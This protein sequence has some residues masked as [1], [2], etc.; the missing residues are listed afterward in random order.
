MLLLAAAFFLTALLYASV[1]FGGGSTYIALLVLTGVTQG[2]VPVVAPLCNIIV[3]TGG[4]IRY[5]RVGLVPWRRVVPLVAASAPMAYLGGLTPVSETLFVALLAGSLLVAGLLLLVQPVRAIE[6][7]RPASRAG[8]AA[9]GSAIGYLSGLVG[10]GGGIFLSPLQHLMRWAGARQIAATAS[11]FIL[12]NALAGL[13][14]QLTKL[15]TA[16]LTAIVPFWPLFVA[17]A[18]GG[19]LAATPAS[20]C[21]VRVRCGARRVR[22]CLRSRRNCCGKPSRIRA[23]DRFADT[24]VSL[25]RD[26]VEHVDVL[27]VGAGLSGIGMAWHLQD[28]CPGKSYAIVEAR[29]AIGGTWDLFRYPGIRSDSDMFTLGYHFKPWLGEKSIADGASIRDYV[30]EAAHEHGIDRHIR[31]GH[32][33]ER[34]EWSSATATWTVSCTRGGATVT[35]SAGFVVMASG[36]YRYDDCYT[37]HFEGL[38]DFAGQV[39]HPQHWPEA[40]DY[41]GKRIVVI[42]SGATAMTL[43][44]ALAE[45]AGHVVMLQRSPTYVADVPARDARADGFRRRLPE[46]LA[47]RAARAWKI[48]QSMAMFKLMRRYPARARQQLI[49][50][51]R[52]ALGPDYDV[53]RHFTPRYNPWDQRLCA[54]PDGDLFAAIRSGKVEVV[55]E[56][57]DRFVADGIRLASGD[58]LP[59]DIVVTAT[60][61][62]MQLFGGAALVV[63]GEPVAM[64][65]TMLYKGMMIGGVPNMSVMIGYN[66]ASWT[67]KA[68]LSAQHTCRIVNTMARRARRLRRRFSTARR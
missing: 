65:E 27:I 4:T 66:N 26:R 58:V 24:H 1:G 16:G 17:V 43:V 53:D 62:E 21:S 15:G 39:V 6:T 9:L 28:R 46:K 48:A 5:A 25:G 45:R 56:V 7:A 57:I 8:D 30:V 49:D 36:Y 38:G 18:I 59:A 63:D 35:I 29:D 64:S 20:G 32:K 3:V 55:T 33:V 40:L 22:W 54:V 34:I 31:F 41:D 10:I 68:D 61:L 52:V 12:V 19:R 23:G 44:P 50:M 14:G 47:Y 67:L 13:A 60:G 42:G 51:V 11:L 37:P 2:L